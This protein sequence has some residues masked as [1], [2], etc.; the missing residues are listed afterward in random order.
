MS[1]AEPQTQI[2]PTPAWQRL[3]VMATPFFAGMLTSG[4]I[5]NMADGE[6]MWAAFKAVGALFLL[7]MTWHWLGE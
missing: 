1:V 5:D 7:G 6:T 4:A 3:L 2:E